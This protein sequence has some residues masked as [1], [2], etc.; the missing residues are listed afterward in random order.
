MSERV[1][2]KWTPDRDTPDD[3]EAWEEV[4]RRVYGKYHG[5]VRLSQRGSR[6]RVQEASPFFDHPA[7]GITFARKAKAKEVFVALFTA[8][9]PVTF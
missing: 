5:Q 3:V 8:G 7:D 2:V 1:T 4:I 9:F 6:W